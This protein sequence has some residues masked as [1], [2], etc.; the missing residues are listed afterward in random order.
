MTASHFP[1][2][3]ANV[4]KTI[5]AGAA[6]ALLQACG[7]GGG[8]SSS[9]DPTTPTSP[10]TPTPPSITTYG[11]RT[12]PGRL[13]VNAPDGRAARLMDL[14]LGNQVSLP[15]ST[16]ASFDVWSASQN[17]QTLVRWTRDSGLNSY[18]VAWFDAA[19]LAARGTPQAVSSLLGLSDLQLS[20]D[21]KWA[22]AQY[23]DNF[24][25]DR[26]L[27]VFDASNMSVQK[28]GSQLDGADIVGDPQAWL[29]D[30]RY[31]YLRANELWVSSPT[32]TTS[33]LVARLALPSNDAV[34]NTSFVAGQSSLAVSPDGTRIAFT[35]RVK[36]GNGM[37][38]HIFTARADGSDIKQ[39]TAVA[40]TTDPLG[41]AFGSPTW[42]PDGQW[43][44]FVLYMN[45]ATAAPV[46]PQDSIGAAKVVGTTGC[47]ASPAYVLPASQAQ[48][49]AFTW[50]AVKQELAL[51]MLA[52]TGGGGEWVTTCSTLRWLP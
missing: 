24:Q 38:T 8:G 30:G 40:D 47:A 21:G 29:P 1:R 13:L 27:T 5:L 16:N 7:G 41:Y 26:R 17:G 14:S 50:P 20:A 39:M 35:W 25:T 18:P 11:S 43:L 23:G 3:P 49:Q 15:A 52:T 31:L 48:A 33:E 28:Q 42:S 51:K 19:T 2:I 10:T 37:D 44:A 34:D 4:L 32:S 46:W 45:G 36:R 9:P 22:L 12:L 6:L